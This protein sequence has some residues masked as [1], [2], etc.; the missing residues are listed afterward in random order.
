LIQPVQKQDT[1]QDSDHAKRGNNDTTKGPTTEAGR[2]KAAEKAAAKEAK[3]ARR[4]EQNRRKNEKKREKARKQREGPRE[5]RGSRR[6]WWTKGERDEAPKQRTAHSEPTRQQPP[7][8]VRQTPEERLEAILAQDMLDFSQLTRQFRRV[9][10][11]ALGDDAGVAEVTKRFRRMSLRYHPDKHH[12]GDQARHAEVFQA[13][14]SAH[15]QLI[16]ELS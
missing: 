13:L 14:N 6:F 5:E 2:Q 10:L 8:G 4:T 9:L 3:A 16:Q 1:T 15:D 12:D 7:R 11:H